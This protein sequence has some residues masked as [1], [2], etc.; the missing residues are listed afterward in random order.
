ME[1][2]D[3]GVARSGLVGGPLFATAVVEVLVAALVEA[4]PH[5]H[6][7]WVVVVGGGVVRPVVPVP[8]RCVTH[9]QAARVAVPQLGGTQRDDVA[10]GGLQLD[11]GR[12]GARDGVV[13]RHPQSSEGLGYAVALVAPRQGCELRDGLV[14]LGAAAMRTGDVRERPGVL[15]AHRGR[16]VVGERAYKGH[17][18]LLA[19]CW[20]QPEPEGPVV[21]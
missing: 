7:P 18:R 12:P 15:S 2:V 13:E 6:W 17:R 8:G 5:R 11:L 14:H 3:Q 19:P 1:Q 21:L 10:R 20:H 9:H 4:L 16:A